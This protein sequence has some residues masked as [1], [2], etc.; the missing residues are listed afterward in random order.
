[1]T[2]KTSG[3]LSFS[4]IQAEFGGAHPISLSEYYRGGGRV[5][6]GTSAV[7]ASGLIRL[8][9]FYGTSNIVTKTARGTNYQPYNGRVK[10]ED[11]PYIWF[12]GATGSDQKVLFD[13]IIDWKDYDIPTSLQVY[14]YSTV[15]LKEA[16]ILKWGFEVKFSYASKYIQP[17]DGST[18]YFQFYCIPIM[19]FQHPGSSYYDVPI[20]G[21]IG[22]NLSGIVQV[23]YGASNNQ[24]YDVNNYYGIDWRPNVSGALYY[25][26]SKYT[27]LT[28]GK[29]EANYYNAAGEPVPYK[30]I[31]M[32][33]SDGNRSNK[34]LDSRTTPSLWELEISYSPA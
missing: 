31:D 25:N 21:W 24:F 15:S 26:G 8:S 7:P 27:D 18:Y 11:S 16:T 14:D 20:K 12:L 4:E 13:G 32:A 17:Y 19:L 10:E 3:T 5:P 6:S 22:N 23:P 1:M 34:F 9:N 30:F 2:I 28:F 29:R 33:P